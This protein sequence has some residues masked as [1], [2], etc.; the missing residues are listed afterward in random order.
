MHRG[1]SSSNASFP[2]GSSEHCQLKQL[3]ASWLPWLAATTLL[4]ILKHSTRY[5]PEGRVS[6]VSCGGIK[7]PRLEALNMPPLKQFPGVQAMPHPST[8]SSGISKGHLATQVKAL[9]QSEENPMTGDLLCEWLQ[10][11]VGCLCVLLGN[12]VQKGS[13]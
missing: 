3:L 4:W 9:I 1:V 12:T 10:E 5:C 11:M 13:R 7:K 6:A 8:S 2:L